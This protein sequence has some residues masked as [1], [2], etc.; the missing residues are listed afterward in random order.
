M[1]QI[2]ARDLTAVLGA[3]EELH[4]D[5]A[6]LSIPEIVMRAVSRIVPNDLI[7]MDRFPASM[8]AAPAHWNNNPEMLPPRILAACDEIFSSFPIDN[9]LIREHI[10]K[11]NRDVLR[12]SDFVEPASFSRTIYFNEIMRPVGFT[13]QMSVMLPLEGDAAYSCAIQRSGRNFTERERRMLAALSPHLAGALRHHER[14]LAARSQRASYDVAFDAGRLGVIGLDARGRVETIGGMAAALVKRH[15]GV[16][17][18]KGEPLPAKASEWMRTRADAR[19]SSPGGG[20]LTITK[21][22]DATTAAT[23][24]LRE[25]E[26]INAEDLKMLGLTTRQAEVLYWMWKGRTYSVI[27]EL[28]GLSR[29]TVEKHVQSMFERLGVE[30][31]SAA[32]AAATSRIDEM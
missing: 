20:S 12:L 18:V 22:E 10:F 6:T 1:V 27:A 24:L 26:S 31:R 3:I 7:A 32:V 23:L 19:E 11:G 30:T 2:S 21:I 13:R 15:I 14:Y 28:M 9:P 29:R 4:F 8:L 5:A 16:N 25:R 17:I